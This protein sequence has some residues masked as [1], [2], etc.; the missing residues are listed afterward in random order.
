MWRKCSKEDPARGW[1]QRTGK[2]GRPS[3]CVTT[4]G[5]LQSSA[6]AHSTG[7]F[8]GGNS[9]SELSLAKEGSH[10]QES[11]V[12]NKKWGHI[13]TWACSTLCT[14]AEWAPAIWGGPS[15]KVLQGLPVGGS[16]TMLK[17]GAETGKNLSD[18]GTL[19]LSAINE[20]V[21]NEKISFRKGHA[22]DNRSLTHC[23]QLVQLTQ[24][25]PVYLFLDSTCIFPT[26]GFQ[27]CLPSWNNLFCLVFKRLKTFK[28]VESHLNS[29][30]RTVR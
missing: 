27:L 15:S 24:L 10:T 14:W 16:G 19:K 2:E 3:N 29:Y 6:G 11:L 4:D 12:K 1:I 23:I 21:W 22:R 20:E 25:P 18:R 9:A 30:K 5:G 26:N 28:E 8:E 13:N 7:S 17:A